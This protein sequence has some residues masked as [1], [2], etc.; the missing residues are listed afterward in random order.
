MTNIKSETQQI[1]TSLENGPKASGAS[2][3][4]DNKEWRS[5]IIIHSR[6]HQ[7]AHAIL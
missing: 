2:G 7:E 6:S 3:S 4:V 1:Y 5:S